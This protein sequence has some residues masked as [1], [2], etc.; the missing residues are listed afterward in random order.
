MAWDLD[1]EWAE[2]WTWSRWWCCKTNQH[3]LF[4]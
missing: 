1:C 3:N 4:E 2:A